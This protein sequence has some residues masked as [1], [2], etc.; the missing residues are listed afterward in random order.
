MFEPPLS[1]FRFPDLSLSPHH[2]WKE[3]VRYCGVYVVQFDVRVFEPIRDVK[4]DNPFE[5]Y[6]SL[7]EVQVLL[8]SSFSI[9]F[10]FLFSCLLS[11][12]GKRIV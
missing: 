5:M 6:I 1:S 2:G 7:E 12:V 8:S 10:P 3:E 4:I 11:C 9:I